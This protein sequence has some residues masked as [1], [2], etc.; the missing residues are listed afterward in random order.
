MVFTGGFGDKLSFKQMSAG[1]RLCT[2][3]ENTLFWAPT[4]KVR[5]PDGNIGGLVG[6]IN[7][8]TESMLKIIAGFRSR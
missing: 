2:F 5:P 8:Q 6:F 1:G 7:C 3:Q 4:I